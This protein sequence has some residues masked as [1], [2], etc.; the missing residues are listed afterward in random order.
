MRGN[1]LGN[2]DP[3][4]EF[5]YSN[6]TSDWLG[7]IVARAC[8]TDLKSFAEEHLFLPL[9]VVDELDMVIVVTADPLYGQTGQEPWKHE[10]A[11]INLVSEF[12]SSL[13]TE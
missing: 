9:E 12:I 8:G 11:N 13:P 10:K 5:N 6:L 3:G 1:Q 2:S 7:M 4:T